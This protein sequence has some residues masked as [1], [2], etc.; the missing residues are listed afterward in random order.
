LCPTAGVGGSGVEP[1]SPAT[2]LLVSFY[3]LINYIL[4]YLPKIGVFSLHSLFLKGHLYDHNAMYVCT[5]VNPP[6]HQILI[7]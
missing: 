3:F 2:T 4:L 7:A 5:Y 1:W 6:P